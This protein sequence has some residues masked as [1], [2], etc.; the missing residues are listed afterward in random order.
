MLSE[1]KF[2]AARKMV[3]SEA[4]DDKQMAKIL[5][6]TE[7]EI[8]NV[9]YSGK[10]YAEYQSFCNKVDAERKKNDL[11]R[12]ETIMETYLLRVI[13]LLTEQNKILHQI[14]ILSGLPDNNQ[15]FKKPF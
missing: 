14:A 2:F 10:G 5:K 6:T 1:E 15:E 3:E 11:P 8:R 9:R 13:D 7:S 4:F 12:D